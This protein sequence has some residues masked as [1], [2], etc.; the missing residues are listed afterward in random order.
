MK[1]RSMCGL[2]VTLALMFVGMIG[3]GIVVYIE[4]RRDEISR[5]AA[6]KRKNHGLH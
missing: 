1:G 4:D 2:L 5:L 6:E 3:I